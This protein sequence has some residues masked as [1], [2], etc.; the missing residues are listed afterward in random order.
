MLN[1]V[2][3]SPLSI[4]LAYFVIR[5]F[6]KGVYSLFY[7]DV[8][9]WELPV[10]YAFFAL[11]CGALFFLLM[12]VSYKISS[13]FGS[14]FKVEAFPRVG[15]QNK[16]LINLSVIIALVVC[17]LSFYVIA[18][19]FG[20]VSAL[21]KNQAAVASHVLELNLGLFYGLMGLAIVP[22]H[23]YICYL[24]ETQSSAVLKVQFI[25]GALILLY[26]L[27]F[28]ILSRRSVILL[29]V[30]P[31]VYYWN[32]NIRNI[33]Y[34]VIVSLSVFL[35]FA[36]VSMVWYR[37]STYS[38]DLGFQQLLSSPEFAIF[39]CFALVAYHLDYLRGYINISLVNGDFLFVNYLGSIVG[40]VLFG[41]E[42]VGGSIP[43]SLIGNALILWG[44]P[45]VIIYP[46]VLGGWLSFWFRALR[47]GGVSSLFFFYGLTFTVTMLS[48]GDVLL[49]LKLLARYYFL[50]GLMVLFFFKVRLV[51]AR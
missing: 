27:P 38:D 19:R 20:G 1:R 50:L 46:I 12:V 8:L 25:G 9:R 16:V 41:Y 43:P 15:V 37:I 4:I 28:I 2:L 39:D 23:V 44:L 5:F 24:L 14:G 31:L 47:S 30:I 49:T 40:S 7:P 35:I 45:G 36:F 13:L 18:S 51:S 34:R 22:I 26:C 3:F 48:N 21:L 10:D 42:F 33:S 29:A 6:F 11:I 17:Y 32:F